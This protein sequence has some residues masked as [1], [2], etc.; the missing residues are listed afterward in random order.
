[1]SYKTFDELIEKNQEQTKLIGKTINF[2]QS[3]FNLDLPIN[4]MLDNAQSQVQG[5][6]TLTHVNDP[7]PHDNLFDRVDRLHTR[8]TAAELESNSYKETVKNLSNSQADFID[9][10]NKLLPDEVKNVEGEPLAIRI[11]R[12]DNIYQEVKLTLTNQREIN[13][14][15]EKVIETQTKKTAEIKQR[16]K[17][18]LGKNETLKGQLSQLEKS[19]VEASKTLDFLKKRVAE[20]SSYLDRITELIPEKDLIFTLENSFG[21]DLVET[22]KLLVDKSG[23]R[24]KLAE[25]KAIKGY[26]PE[27]TQRFEETKALLK[28]EEEKNIELMREQNHVRNILKNAFEFDS[29]KYKQ[30]GD[31]VNRFCVERLKDRKRLKEVLQ[32]MSEISDSLPREI[33]LSS[34]L[35]EAVKQTVEY[36]RKQRKLFLEFEGG[37][38]KIKELEKKLND[39]RDVM[40]DLEK[41]RD[42]AQSQVKNLTEEREKWKQ[43]ALAL[44]RKLEPIKDMVKETFRKVD[45]DIVEAIRIQL[46]KKLFLEEQVLG[47]KESQENLNTLITEQA[48]IIKTKDNGLKSVLEELKKLQEKVLVAKEVHEQEIMNYKAVFKL[49][50]SKFQA[51]GFNNSGDSI[52]NKFIKMSDSYV[53]LEAQIEDSQVAQEILEDQNQELKIRLK[54]EVDEL[55][56]GLDE[57]SRKDSQKEAKILN[58]QKSLKNS[59]E[60]LNSIYEL[61]EEILGEQTSLDSL[62]AV[63]SLADAYKDQEYELNFNLDLVSSLEAQVTYFES[64]LDAIKSYKVRGND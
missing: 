8:M 35:V 14:N 58:L 31:A 25:E 51:L 59:S 44:F 6:L 37:E 3:G 64:I 38:L 19:K 32:G 52:T 2:L 40:G 22:I 50:E 26:Q 60:S 24:D 63:R 11:N 27:L 20:F 29:Y 16:N 30:I 45:G 61:V 62:E 33:E 47:L 48:D 42:N 36:G 56:L 9:N 39:F 18:L 41:E 46:N 55:K 1:M 34:S 49:L 57:F 21:D 10:L 28:A 5:I 43:D 13:K 15:Q 4:E 53:N 7:D 12:L 17:E 54:K 23:E